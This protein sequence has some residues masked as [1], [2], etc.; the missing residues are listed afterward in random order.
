LEAMIGPWSLTL[1]IGLALVALM[2]GFSFD[3]KLA[4]PEY[5]E[6]GES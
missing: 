3:T 6:A 2:L 4:E 5:E 1:P